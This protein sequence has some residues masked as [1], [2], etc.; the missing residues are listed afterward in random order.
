[1]E[2]RNQKIL[3][4]AE[5]EQCTMNSPWCIGDPN[6]V[7]AA[8]SNMQLHGKGR[9]IKAHDLFVAFCCIGCHRYYD[10]S[11]APR[12]EKEDLFFRANAR[13]LIRLIEKGI[14]K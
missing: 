6:S 11:D 9:G 4:A 10:E 13:T 8:H 2:Y 1:M 7:C 14:L 12:A 5:G 3:D